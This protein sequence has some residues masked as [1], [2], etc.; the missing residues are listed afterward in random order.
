MRCEIFSIP[1][2][3]NWKKHMFGINPPKYN[4]IFIATL[5]S[6]SIALNF[7]A[8]ERDIV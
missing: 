1:N 5:A 3:Y 2:N 4:F 8:T 7:P 6:D